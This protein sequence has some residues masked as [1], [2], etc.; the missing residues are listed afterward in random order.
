M[1][2]D[3]EV[4]REIQH[5]LLPKTFPTIPGLK[6]EAMNLPSKH[7]GG[8]YYDV[9]LLCE[10][11]VALVIAD[12]SG[13][14]VPAA[15]LMASLQSTLR[16]EASAG[17]SPSKVISILNREIFEHTA[18]GTFVTI[19][20]GVMDLETE[21]MT[22]CNAGH[23]PPIIL[24]KDLDTRLLDE[25]H[26]VIGIDNEAE[27][28][29]TTVKLK[30]GDLLFLYTDGITDELDERDEPYGETRLLAKLNQLRDSELIDILNSVH[31]AVVEYTGGK[32]QDDLTALAVTIEAFIP[33]TTRIA[34]RNVRD[35]KKD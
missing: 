25:T 19:F 26:I 33:P 28:A 13:K 16:A 15:L 32:P 1:E 11:K 8:D 21:T 23:P 2:K 9:I 27:Y 24:G 14:G 31:D 5:R 20:Y 18:G 6:T 3:L 7:V 34:A 30:P 29:D 4:A 17:R 22:Y 10:G 12:V 35:A